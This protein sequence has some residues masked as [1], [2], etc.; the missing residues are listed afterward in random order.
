MLDTEA[1]SVAEGVPMSNIRL[2]S[3]NDEVDNIR[4]F[5]FETDDTSWQPGQYRQY[6]ISS[7]QGDE[8]ARRHYFTIASAPSEDVIH[9]STRVTDSPFKQAL[10]K[11]EPGDAIEVGAVEG[12]FTIDTNEPVVFVAAGIGVTPFR[13]MIVERTMTSKPLPFH[14]VYYG[15]DNSFAFKEL[16]D[17]TA[18]RHAEFTVDY[19]VGEHVSAESI[20]AH[21]PEAKTRTV[22]ISGPEPMVDAV[23]PD[24]EKAGV[25]I[26]QDWFPGYTDQ[27]Y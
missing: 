20:L 18:A 21:A 25:T 16:F 3:S 19:I 26:K 17:A 9:I 14:L 13:S 11:L 7:V 24:L 5:V 23:G 6:T 22:Y 15:R 2:I 10:Q 12:D 1:A 27:T 8:A 4:T